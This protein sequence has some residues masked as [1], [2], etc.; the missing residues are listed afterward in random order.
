[1]AKASP[2]L[3]GDFFWRAFGAELGSTCQLEI[4]PSKG[5]KSEKRMNDPPV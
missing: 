5:K 4:L 2:Q 3:N 1:M